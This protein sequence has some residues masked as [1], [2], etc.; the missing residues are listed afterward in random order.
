MTII[1]SHAANYCQILIGLQ[2]FKMNVWKLVRECTILV[3]SIFK[4]K[5]TISLFSIKRLNKLTILPP[6]VLH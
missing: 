2:N 1:D 6:G 4:L 3:T 5:V